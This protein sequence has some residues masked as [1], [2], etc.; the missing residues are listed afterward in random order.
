MHA[1]EVERV[2]KRYALGARHDS[3]RDMIPSMIKRVV[4]GNGVPAKH[5]FW[6][7]QDVSFQVKRGETL[8][9]IGPN[10]AGKSTM[11]KLLSRICRQNRGEVRVHGRLAALIEVGAGFHQDLTGKENIYLN[12]TIM[13]LRRKEIDRKLDSI[14]AFSE[15]EK[16]LE[17]PVKR[18]SSGMSVRLGFAVAAHIN[19]E[20]LLVDEVLAVGDLAFQQK[21]YQ[22]ILDLKESGTTIIFISH[23]LESVHR[24]CD[25]VVLLD[26]G[27][28]YQDGDPGEVIL[29]YRQDVLKRSRSQPKTFHGHAVKDP[30]HDVEMF[31][32]AL[33]DGN[34]LRSDTFRTGAAMRVQFSVNCLRDIRNPSITVRLE[35]FDGL[36]CHESSTAASGLSW[37]ALK[38]RQDFVVDYP[39]V[40]LLPHTYQVIISIFEGRNPVP[41]KQLKNDLYFHISS[42]RL[43]AGAVHLDH[44]WRTQG[45]GE[46]STPLVHPGPGSRGL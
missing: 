12:G 5:E 42:D 46:R 2:W 38:G 30:S 4:G 31:N 26:R 45:N 43:A 18:Y 9:I 6:A 15:L 29:T 32:T 36:L 16:F 17:M 1:I 40:D 35:R 28:V 8:G 21:C 3:L 20:V 11:L 23:N 14:V 24:L 39:R 27:R 34:G 22:R 33:L 41:L 19:P 7:L 25:R 13:G 10:G 44:H 37:E